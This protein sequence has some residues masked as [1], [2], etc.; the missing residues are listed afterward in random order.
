MP[1]HEMRLI[2]R[3]LAL[4]HSS[5]IRPHTRKRQ[6]IIRASPARSVC[7]CVSTDEDLFA[8]HEFLSLD[9]AQLL[10]ALAA[11]GLAHGEGL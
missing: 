8:R 10:H 2:A 4:C 5:T 9:A 6:R 7:V 11:D 3:I 1:S